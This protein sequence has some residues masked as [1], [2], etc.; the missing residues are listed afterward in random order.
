MQ[1]SFGARLRQR[2]EEQGIDLGT[3]AGQTK[4][5]LSLLQALERDDVSHW[6]SGIYRRAYIRTY[7]KS[8]GLDPDVIAREFLD[9]YP[10]PLDVAALAEIASLAEGARTQGGPPTRLRTIMGSAL[11][12]LSRLRRGVAV[13]EHPEVHA[14]PPQAAF[15]ADADTDVPAV[16]TVTA[17]AEAAAVPAPEPDPVESLQPLASEPPP[18]YAQTDA[19]L[20]IDPE[21]PA[22][23]PPP[24]RVPDLVAVAQLCTRFAQVD[25]Q[26][27]LQRLLQ[28]SA[29]L[30]DA[31]GL[32]I[33]LRDPSSD[34]L[35][36][37][38]AYGYPDR[39]L[40]HLPMVRRDADNATAA[41]F[42]SGEVRAIDGDGGCSGALVVPLLTADGCAGV[43]AVELQ[44]GCAHTEPLKAV[45][46]IL[47]AS[48]SL[49]VGSA[50][51]AEVP[52]TP[53]FV[54]H[55][56]AFAAR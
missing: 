11:G 56:P 36:P 23:S 50:R 4:I 35:R 40:A 55:A 2:R 1:E 52:A 29:A 24:L 53:D 16:P 44:Q 25:R 14:P 49:L 33:W 39:V 27:E 5:K 22:P 37:A 26:Q 9:A 10:E 38:L 51:P 6:P 31:K 47:A 48:L 43:L 41:A 8:I 18:A 46:M 42:R 30:L 45:A 7:A 15:E 13:D 21:P 12:S 34:G 28:Q 3:I 17:Y 32:I 20:R 19:D 54:P